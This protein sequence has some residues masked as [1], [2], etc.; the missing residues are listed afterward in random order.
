[1]GRGTG[2]K[3]VKVQA[4]GPL[5]EVAHSAA[6]FD[7]PSSFDGGQDVHVGRNVPGFDASPI[8]IGS[9]WR[10]WPHKIFSSATPFGR[11]YR[12][13]CSK[14]PRS[15]CD[16]APNA[17]LWPCPLPYHGADLSVKKNGERTAGFRH[18]VNLQISYLSFLHVGQHQLP[19]D[20]VCG[21]V[22]LTDQQKSMVRRVEELASAWAEQKA[23]SA[24]DMGRTAAKQERQEEIL[25]KL[26]C[27]SS[28]VVQGL[29]KYQRMSQKVELCRPTAE[30]GKVIGHLQKSNVCT[31]Q[32][33]VADRIKMEGRPVFDP[34]PFLDSECKRLFE[35]PFCQGINPD[36]LVDKPPRVRVHASLDE[37]IKLLCLLNKSGRLVF[38]KPSEIIAHHG[39]GL[40][41]VPKNLDVDRLILDGRPANQLQLTPDKYILSMGAATPLLGIHLSDDEKLLM[42]GDDLSNFFYT[43]K[44]GH[45]RASR[46]FLDWKIGTKLVKNFAG[47][48]D[49]LKSER[50]VYACLNTLAMG[51]SAACEYAQTSHICMGLIS[52]A[53][54][55]NNL[56]TLHG[57][58]PRHSTLSGIIIDD[59]ILMQKVGI[60]ETRGVDMEHRR[61]AMHDMYKQVGL[62]AHPTKG[63]SNSDSASFWGADVDGLRGLVRGNVVRAGSLCWITSKIACLG[64]ATVGLLEM[65]SGGFVALFGFRRRMMSL[66]DL[67]YAAQAGRDQGDVVQLSSALRDELW[68][69]CILCPLAVT[70]L[71]ASFCN[72]VYMVDASNWGDA[73]CAAELPTGLRSEMH[74]HGLSRSTWTKLLSPYKANLKGKGV[75]D[76]EE[77][78]PPGEIPYSSHP[79]WEVAARGLVYEVRWKRRARNA[80]H[81]NIGEL[82]SYLKAEE[83]VGMH[84]SDVRVCIGGDSQITAGAICKGRSASHVL[85]RELRKSLPNLLGRGVYSSPGYVYTKHNPADDP[86]RGASLR[87]PDVELPEWWLC[88]AQ[89]AYEMLDDML[90]H[91]GLDDND[92]SGHAPLQDLFP[93]AENRQF[94]KHS[95]R[96]KNNLH[97]RVQEKLSKRHFLKFKE[98][99]PSSISS[100]EETHLWPSDIFDDLTSF[101]KEAFI[102]GSGFQWP[103]RC[104]GLLDL[105]SGRKGFAKACSRLG[106]PWVLTIDIEDGP[107]FDLL[108]PATRRKLERLIRGGCF[109]HVSCAPICASFSRAITPAVRS[110]AEPL[111]IK[112]IRQSLF[113][114]IV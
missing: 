84:A 81:I 45:D 87:H 97:K 25:K 42:S 3:A 105:Y 23:F 38:R 112:P 73:V 99:E 72:E 106:A 31:A 48:P 27:F 30:R 86:T 33:I 71:R 91:D 108:S 92:I 40:F 93:S 26:E 46:N 44:I 41:C 19:P 9:M 55:P 88:A 1:M 18:I 58:T 107:Q 21:P 10:T 50:Y 4:A 78:L 20:R 36:S 110:K 43:F 65:V 75:L 85:N 82:R 104:P 8:D 64:V 83:I 52:G 6:E 57:R 56:L 109:L 90:K 39:N 11:Y 22:A 103:P 2:G 29:S 101:G 100:I 96:K 54:D 98:S 28:S 66:L 89:G 68:S 113:E 53:I 61:A 32:R 17:E 15:Q 37:K 60:E 5:S 94:D 14:S 47:F 74:R 63:F 59:F 16:V 114:K 24:S 102:F 35:E 12:A 62:E 111:G 80:R 34:T 77:E 13:Q 95:I 49:A 67:I 70:N 76:P 51:D 7:D 69:L 79:V